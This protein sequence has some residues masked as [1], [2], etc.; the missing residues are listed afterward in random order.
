MY[1]NMLIYSLFVHN[2]SAPFASTQASS[3]SCPVT[4][5]IAETAS[6]VVDC[7]NKTKQIT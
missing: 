7:A 2:Q 5:S 6:S 4:E 3:P 1:I